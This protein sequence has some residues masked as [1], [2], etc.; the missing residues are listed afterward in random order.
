MHF[1]CKRFIARLLL[2]GQLLSSCANPVRL[3]IG[4]A[5]RHISTRQPDQ[6]TP[7]IPTIVQTY[8]AKGGHHVTFSKKECSWKAKVVENRPKKWFYQ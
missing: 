8:L 3:R 6:A 2:F 1:P 7:F 5:P 4:H